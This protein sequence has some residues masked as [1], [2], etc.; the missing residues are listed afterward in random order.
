MCTENQIGGR[1]R[2]IAR[3]IEALL[4]QRM[5]TERRQ[6]WQDKFADKVTRFTGSLMFVYR[7]LLTFGLWIGIN[8]GW[9]PLPKSDSTLVILA[10]AGPV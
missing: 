9:V 3:N 10:M 1:S 7:R 5:K 2:I 4:E 6:R 8:L